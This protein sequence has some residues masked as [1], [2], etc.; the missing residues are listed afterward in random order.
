MGM[1]LEWFWL[2]TI[3]VIDFH[4]LMIH[5]LNTHL[6]LVILQQLELGKFECAILGFIQFSVSQVIEFLLWPEICE[7]YF[8]SFPQKIY[9][10]RQ[11]SLSQFVC[12]LSEVCLLFNFW[13]IKFTI[14]FLT[15]LWIL[16]LKNWKVNTLPSNNI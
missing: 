4:Q 12:F 6:H 16:S 7:N 15:Y 11:L 9:K 1:V 13:M 8:L 2:I 3:L 10:L 14:M 5:H